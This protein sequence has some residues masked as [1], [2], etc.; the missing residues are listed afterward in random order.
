MKHL[1]VSHPVVNNFAKDIGNGL[2]TG[3]NFCMLYI[4]V[5]VSMQV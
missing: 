3:E 2:M 5:Y 1:S 4:L